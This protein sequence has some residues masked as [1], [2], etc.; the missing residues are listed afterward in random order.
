MNSP[1]AIAIVDRIRSARTE[2]TSVEELRE[3]TEELC[4]VVEQSVQAIMFYQ[5]AEKLAF[6]A[7]GVRVPDEVVAEALN[8][9][10]A[11]FLSEGG[12]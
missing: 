2:T 5:V 11:S 8:A 1:E 10:E 4:N 7:T 12:K 9:L 6:M 3:M